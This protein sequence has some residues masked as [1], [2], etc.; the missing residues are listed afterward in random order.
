MVGQ[1]AAESSK[2]REGLD[3]GYP[4]VCDKVLNPFSRIT[5]VRE[6]IH[7]ASDDPFQCNSFATS[8]NSGEVRGFESDS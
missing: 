4:R 2:P 1:T 3:H 6:L 7:Q 5:T 8:C